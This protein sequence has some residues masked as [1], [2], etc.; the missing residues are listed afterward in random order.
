MH[1][2]VI[3]ELGDAHSARVRRHAD[4]CEPCRRALATISA[5]DDRPPAVRRAPRPRRAV[6]ALSVAAPALAIALLAYRLVGPPDLQTKG[7][8]T[9][10]P[11]LEIYAR[12]G[13]DPFRVAAGTPLRPADEIRFVVQRP[14]AMTHVMIASVEAGG[15]SN[16]YFPYGGQQ[17]AEIAGKGA[18][19]ELP[20]AIVL[21]ASAGPER[22]FALFSQAPLAWDQVQRALAALG[23]GGPGAV[24]GALSLTVEA[25]AQASVLVEK[26]AP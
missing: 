6:L 15:A 16:L 10:Q 21:D 13:G 22:V 11:Q 9:L 18:R 8:G 23:R 26:A 7:G 25:D 24:R 5:A 17:S 4:R 12:R 19:V 20:G 14:G 3:G 1:G 2:H